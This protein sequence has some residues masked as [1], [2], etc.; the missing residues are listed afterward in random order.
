MPLS[1]EDFNRELGERGLR[2]DDLTVWEWDQIEGVLEGAI[3]RMRERYPKHKPMMRLAD[4]LWELRNK[5][6]DRGKGAVHTLRGED[7]PA[8]PKD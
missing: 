7:L 2:I 4:R 1:Y 8:L 6:R 5:I 3:T